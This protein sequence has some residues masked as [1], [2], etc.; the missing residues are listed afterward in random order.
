MSV[1]E[2]M[3]VVV[4]FPSRVDSGALSAG[5][6]SEKFEE[7]RG[8]EGMHLTRR[9]KVL[10]LAL[11]LIA[12]MALGIL[13]GSVA[14]AAPVAAGVPVV[15]HAVQH[16]ESLWEIALELEQG[17]DTR[18]VVAE[19]M[20]INGLVSADLMAGQLVYLPERR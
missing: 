11:S 14:S 13:V 20:K 6:R 19:I 16:G 1:Q 17:R 5:R 3:G 12:S 4:E 2:A 8:L 9:G 10:V 7:P 15:A 18:D